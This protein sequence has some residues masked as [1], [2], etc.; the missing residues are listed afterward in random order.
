MTSMPGSDLS[1]LLL[2]QSQRREDRARRPR[3]ASA[4][5][6]RP[7]RGSRPDAASHPPSRPR[8]RD[9][10][11]RDRRHFPTM[12]RPAVSQHLR[13]LADAGLVAVRADGNRRLYRWRREGL[14][15]AAAFVEEMWTDRLTRLKARPSGRSGQSGMRAR[16]QE[17][18]KGRRTM[19]DDR[20][21]GSSSRQCN[22]RDGPETVWRYWTDPQRM[23]DWWGGPPSS[24]PAGRRVRVRWIT[25]D[26]ARRV[27]R[28]RARTADRVQLGWEPAKVASSDRARFDARRGDV[29]R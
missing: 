25:A 28:A 17:R 9:T 14:R 29:D 26:H 12:S 18:R 5:G 3:G 27:P 15:D 21:R 7:A 13:V 10:G 20:H 1:K 22:Q 23:S 8:R 19:V 24:S 2:T 16:R 6:R 11:G 4:D